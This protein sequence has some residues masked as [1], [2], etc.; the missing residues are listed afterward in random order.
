[1]WHP[2]KIGGT[3]SHIEDWMRSYQSG[4]HRSKVAAGPEK[5]TDEYNAGVND[6]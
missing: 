2:K 4:D 5:I 3:K 6:A 1:V